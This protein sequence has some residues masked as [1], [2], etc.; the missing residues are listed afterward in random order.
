MNDDEELYREMDEDDDFYMGDREE[1]VEEEIEPNNNV[2]NRSG[3][4][5]AAVFL[6]VAGS[7]FLFI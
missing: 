5:A 7:L 4:M 6:I 2:Q 1:E 3:C